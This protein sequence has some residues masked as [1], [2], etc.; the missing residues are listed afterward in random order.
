[1]NTVNEYFNKTYN[2]AREEL[3]KKIA[4]QIDPKE[5]CM[6]GSSQSQFKDTTV[7]Q[8]LMQRTTAL[9][10]DVSALTPNER[11]TFTL[12]LEEFDKIRHKN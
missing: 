8:Y 1:M 4:S 11:V 6:V 5:A 3:I 10:R 12:L 9:A 2:D 7:V